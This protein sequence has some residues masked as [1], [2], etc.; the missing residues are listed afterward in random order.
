M[1]MKWEDIVSKLL[2]EQI[3]KSCENEDIIRVREALQGLL[4]IKSL[5]V[6]IPIELIIDVINVSV[7]KRNECSGLKKLNYISFE[8]GEIMWEL[9]KVAMYLS[10]FLDKKV[11]Y[12]REYNRDKFE[13][14]NGKSS[15]VVRLKDK[16]QGMGINVTGH[17]PKCSSRGVLM[18]VGVEI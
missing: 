16:L 2:D 1:I 14:L 8:N 7:K 6:N 10:E 5:N 13:I 3:I 11:S 18:V 9:D 12:N 4:N 17:Y 15:D